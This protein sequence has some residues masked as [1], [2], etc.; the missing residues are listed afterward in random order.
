MPTPGTPQAGLSPGSKYTKDTGQ[1]ARHTH[2]HHTHHPH[3]HIPLTSHITLTL[4]ITHSSHHPHPAHYPHPSHHSLLT[5]P[6]PCT[7]HSPFTSHITNSL[8][9]MDLLE[10]VAMVTVKQ[11]WYAVVRTRPCFPVAVSGY[12]AL[13]PQRRSLTAP[14][15]PSAASVSF[16]L[17]G[18]ATFPCGT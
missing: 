18:V 6:S 12:P 11:S 13:A 10:S 5:S 4:H 15:P 17:S 16:L 1:Q 2:P 9:T 14:H 3:P 8:G 7:S